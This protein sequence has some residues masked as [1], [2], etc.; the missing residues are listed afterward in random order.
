MCEIS[1]GGEGRGVREGRGV[2]EGREKG[3]ER[4]ES[5]R[6]YMYVNLFILSSSSCLRCLSSEFCLVVITRS[7]LNASCGGWISR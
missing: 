3:S 4:G 2:S 5:G 6:D 7:F 1:E